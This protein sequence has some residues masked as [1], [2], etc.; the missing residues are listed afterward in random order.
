MG[1]NKLVE[2]LLEVTRRLGSADASNVI[3]F[4]GGVDSSLVAKLVHETFPKT[5]VAAIGRSDALPKTQL[6]LAR[7]VAVSLDLCQ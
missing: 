3:A 4:S 6:R 2:H 5:A 7:Q 1:R